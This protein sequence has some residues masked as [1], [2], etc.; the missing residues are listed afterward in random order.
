M[1]REFWATHPD[2]RKPLMAWAKE[3]EAA[4]WVDSA[5]LKAMYRSASILDDQRVVF[6]LCGNKYRLVVWVHYRYG[7]VLTRWIGTHEEYDNLKAES[8]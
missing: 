8:L 1:L 4:H 2:A 6:N 3:V 7:R 5:A